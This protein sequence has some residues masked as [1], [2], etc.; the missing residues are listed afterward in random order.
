VLIVAAAGLLGASART[1]GAPSA[2][3]RASVE[4]AG[5]HTRLTTAK[6]PV[7]LYRP[8]GYDPA[9]AGIV[10]YVHGLYVNADQAWRRHRLGRQFAASKRNALFIVPEAPARADGPVRW[11]EL[12]PLLDLAL[13]RLGEPRPAG[14]LV[15]AGHSGA[16]RTLAS[17][18]GEPALQ[19]LL[20]IDGLYGHA[21][22]FAAWLAAAP[23][24]RMTLV[25]K[26]T[27]KLARPFARR[28]KYTVRISRVPAR[29]TSLSPAARDAKLLYVR[30]QYDHMQLVTEGKTLPVLLQR[31][32]L[33]PL[34]GGS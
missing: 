6:G 12:G 3:P 19:H 26:G 11:T 21:D 22:E 8:A 34:A 9:T 1:A 18:L 4:A 24:N 29:I 10:V 28:H 27:Q 14:P 20:L 25:V 13:G 17:W 30:S 5:T 7:H 15:V 32:P 33:V 23:E 31:T 16:Y 2:E